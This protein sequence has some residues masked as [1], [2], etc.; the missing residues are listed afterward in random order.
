VIAESYDHKIDKSSK[1]KHAIIE[2]RDIEINHVCD[3]I[4]SS[5]MNITIHQFFQINL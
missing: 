3:A 4:E 5:C 2:T 1:H